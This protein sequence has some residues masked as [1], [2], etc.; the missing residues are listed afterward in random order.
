MVGI[1]KYLLYG[2]LQFASL[3]SDPTWRDRPG[4]S[5]YYRSMS[6][7]FAMFRFDNCSRQDYNG[8]QDYKCIAVCL[9]CY[10]NAKSCDALHLKS[11]SDT[12]SDT[13][14]AYLSLNIRCTMYVLLILWFFR[15]K[16]LFFI[17]DES[18]LFAPTPKY[19]QNMLT[20]Y[21]SL[22]YVC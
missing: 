8:Y 10:F 13:G 1:T 4:I 5:S 9:N 19:T 6:V 16:S 18:V 11:A 14:K 21:T 2:I 12:A 22:H 7:V 17:S 15:K 20:L 3:F